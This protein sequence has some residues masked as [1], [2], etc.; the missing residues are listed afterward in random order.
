MIAEHTS[1]F[2]TRLTRAYSWLLASPELLR[3]RA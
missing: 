3:M 1:P 2:M